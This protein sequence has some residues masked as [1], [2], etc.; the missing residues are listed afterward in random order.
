MMGDRAGVNR[1][2]GIRQVTKKS[3]IDL[4]WA[5]QFERLVSGE[6]PDT[7][8]ILREVALIANPHRGA[9]PGRDGQGRCA[10]HRRRHPGN[11][12]D[13]SGRTGG[14]GSG[15]RSAAA[16]RPRA[17]DDRPRQ[18]RRRRLRR[19][20]PDGGGWIRRH[21]RTAHR[22]RAAQG[23]CG[24]R[25]RGLDRPQQGP[26][27][28]PRR[29]S[30]HHRRCPV[31]RRPRPAGGGDGRPDHHRGQSLGPSGGRRRPAERHRRARRQGPRHGH[32]GHLFGHLLPS[33]ARP[34]AQ[35]GPRLC[36]PAAGRRHRHRRRRAGHHPAEDGLEPAGALVAAGAGGGRE[37]I[38]PR[39]CRSWFRARRRAPVPRG[40]RRVRR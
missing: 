16:G 20:P 36:R 17:G 33:E 34:P 24:L 40:W 35:S 1:C 12:P 14:G 23:G 39:P 31:R 6:E 32:Q 22:A 38:R 2:L 30:R 4:E 3:S 8:Q 10:D 29:R 26:F 19:R 21:R 25:R 15:S 11:H 28:R 27:R 9:D 18:Q 7:H 13:G 37:Q 5:S